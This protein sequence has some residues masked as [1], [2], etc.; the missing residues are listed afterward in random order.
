MHSTISRHFTVFYCQYMAIMSKQ[1]KKSGLLT[2]HFFKKSL[3]IGDY[4]IFELDGKALSII[5]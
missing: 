5:H 1:E 2:L 3:W 4:F